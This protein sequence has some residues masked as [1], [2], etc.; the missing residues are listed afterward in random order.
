MG[1]RPSTVGALVTAVCAVG[2]SSTGNVA[3]IGR[4]RGTA[5]RITQS[6]W[7]RLLGRDPPRTVQASA[8]CKN[9]NTGMLHQW[10]SVL[11]EPGGK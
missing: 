6:K 3:E 2:A 9:S 5:D 8:Q 10:R 1:D 11:M 4:P 7:A